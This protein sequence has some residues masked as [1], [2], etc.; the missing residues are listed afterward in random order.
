MKQQGWQYSADQR[1]A[2][3]PWRQSDVGSDLPWEKE[4]RMGRDKTG[5]AV[6]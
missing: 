2:K 4:M 3:F 1:L 5:D 6:S